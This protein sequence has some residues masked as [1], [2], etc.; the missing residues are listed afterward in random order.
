MR[1]RPLVPLALVLVAAACGDD[2]ATAPDGASSRGPSSLISDGTRASE[3]GNKDFFFLPPMVPNPAANQWYD[4]GKFNPLWTPTIKVCPLVDDPATPSTELVCGTPVQT[5]TGVTVDR[6]AELYQFNLDTRATWASAGLYRATVFVEP[7]P[8][9]LEAL[10]FIDFELLPNQQAVKNTQTSDVVP[11]LD[12]RTVPLKFRIEYGATVNQESA[13]YAEQPVTNAGGIVRTVDAATGEPG[14]AVMSFAP[15]WLGSGIS[16][17]IVTITKINEVGPGGGCIAYAPEVQRTGNGCWRVTTLPDIGQVHA[18]V[19][20]GFCPA[21][22]ESDPRYDLQSIYKHDAG[23]PRTLRPLPNADSPEPLVCEPPPPVINL[24]SASGPLGALRQGAAWLARG[25]GKAFGPNTAYALDAGLGG[26]MVAGDEAFSEFLA[27]VPVQTEIVGGNSASGIIGQPLT[28]SVKV[29]SANTH[30]GTSP[31]TFVGDTVYVG[32]V[33]GGVVTGAAFALTNNLGV[34]TFTFTPSAATGS[35][36]FKANDVDPLATTTLAVTAGTSPL[37]NTIVLREGSGTAPIYDRLSMNAVVGTGTAMYADL[38][39]A[40]G[41]PS[42]TS[43]TWS[44]QSSAFSLANPTG[45]AVTVVGQSPTGTQME[46]ATVTC[47]S[48]SRLVFVSVRQATSVAMVWSIDLSI[49]PP[50]SQTPLTITDPLNL[51]TSTSY[52]ATAT[53]LDANQ[54]PITTASCGWFQTH[55]VTL[56]PMTGSNITWT[57][58]VTPTTADNPARVF[59]TCQGFTRELKVRTFQPVT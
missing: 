59:I 26:K 52:A 27:G 10:G 8:G 49:V 50:N 38:L 35:V 25:L 9:S 56:A 34:A 12:G 51:N 57:T 23:P 21:I 33:T 2:R 41:A 19:V 42:G 16:E 14:D 46:Q 36:Q 4:A 13:D 43:C 45:N 47:G 30:P 15:G 58:S 5:F 44:T 22:P 17:V 7:T 24:Q 54:Q 55:T 20:I 6:V 39:N 37:A 3:G 40:A 29:S 31:V 18:D 11:L 1:L 53:P 48:Q 28:V 32:T